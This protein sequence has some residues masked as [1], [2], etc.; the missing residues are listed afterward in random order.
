[1]AKKSSGHGGTRPGAGRPRGR[2]D[3]TLIRAPG[4]L[5][6]MIV[7][8]ARAKGGTAAGYLDK[9]LRAIVTREHARLTEDDKC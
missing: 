2:K 6:R 3:E 7:A 8:I 1:M 4:D 5:A 9:K